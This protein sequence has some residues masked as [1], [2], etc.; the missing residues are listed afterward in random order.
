M[1]I[2]IVILYMGMYLNFRHQWAA[3]DQWVASPSGGRSES[4]GDGRR[5]STYLLGRCSTARAAN[6]TIDEAS[7]VVGA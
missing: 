5:S 6:A 7:L 2:I 1:M 4:V 3:A